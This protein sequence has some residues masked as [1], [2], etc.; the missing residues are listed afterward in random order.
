MIDQKVL[1]RYA[2]HCVADYKRWSKNAEM[3]AK[4]NYSIEFDWGSKFI[5]VW[6][7]SWGQRSCHSFIAIG[8]NP[9]DKWPEGT[10]LKAASWRAP[11]Q[12]FARGSIYDSKLDRVLWTGVM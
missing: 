5:R 1:D 11:A 8:A 2:E 6:S 9:K 3:N 10:I 4:A 12:N 7:S